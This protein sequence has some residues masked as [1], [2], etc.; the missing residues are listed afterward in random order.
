ME[1][2][3]IEE[4]IKELYVNESLSVGFI[5]QTL[6]ID[7]SVICRI[8]TRYHLKHATIKKQVVP[9]NFLDF[10]S[11][12][13]YIYKAMANRP[14]DEIEYIAEQYKLSKEEIE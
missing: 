8:I 5:S 7:K 10:Q 12:L 6:K 9:S 13:D 2:K 3:S 1:E 4:R 11:K 14:Y